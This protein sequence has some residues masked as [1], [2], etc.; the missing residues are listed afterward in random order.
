VNSQ[1]AIVLIHNSRI[2]SASYRMEKS[3]VIFQPGKREKNVFFGVSAWKIEIIF[4]TF[5]FDMHSDNTLF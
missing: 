1:P 3:L 5:A 4:Q 2:P